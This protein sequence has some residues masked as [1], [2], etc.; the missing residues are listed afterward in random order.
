MPSCLAV[1]D[2]VIPWTIA[3]QPPLSME[4]S[5][6]EYWGGLLFSL[7]WL[8]YMY[9]LTPS[10]ESLPPPFHPPRSSQSTKLSS[11]CY[12]AASHQLCI[13]H[14]VVHVSQCY[15]PSSIQLP[16]PL[17]RPHAHSLNLHL[18]SVQFSSVAQSC[19]T[20]RNSGNSGRL[21][22]SGLQ[23]HCRWWLQPWN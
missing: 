10:L 9:T 20:L 3:H 23:N 11:L 4:F 8:S 16:L 1:S 22:F 7:P 14:M 13:L 5:R 15:S 21:Y 18:Y 6:Q 2:F 19:L 12:T 17:L